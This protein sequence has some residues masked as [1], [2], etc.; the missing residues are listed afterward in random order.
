MKYAFIL[1]IFFFNY[2]FAIQNTV[3]PKNLEVKLDKVLKEQFNGSFGT[4]EKILFSSEVLKNVALNHDED[5]LFSIK[6]LKS[7]TLGFAYVGK[8][9]SKVALFDYVV[10]F[11]KNL[12]ITQVKVLIYREDHG[13]EIS[14]KRWLQEF[15]GFEK[16]QTILY[17]KDIAGISGATISAASLTLAVNNVLSTMGKLHQ[18]KQL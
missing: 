8:A 3:I 5:I 6:D 9:K 16:N 15:L 13:G 18:L 11:D 7:K 17:K 10:I 14:S 1:L 12:I 4:K 2:S